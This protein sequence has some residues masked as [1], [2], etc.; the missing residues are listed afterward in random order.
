MLSGSS[1][2]RHV[3]WPRSPMPPLYSL[4][5]TARLQWWTR[6]SRLCATPF[7]RPDK[8]SYRLLN[9]RVRPSAHSPP[10]GPTLCLQP[11]PCLAPGWGLPAP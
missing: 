11:S 5:L 1:V 8:R 9:T 6:I 2:L 7:V 4:E 10:R 3:P